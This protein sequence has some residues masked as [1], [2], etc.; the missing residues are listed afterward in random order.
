MRQCFSGARVRNKPASFAQNLPR[1][2]SLRNLESKRDI[3]TPGELEM[4]EPSAFYFVCRP[5]YR[6][7]LRYIVRRYSP[8]QVRFH[9]YVF[10]NLSACKQLQRSHEK[11]RLFACALL[12]LPV[13][14][15]DRP[16]FKSS[17]QMFAVV[18]PYS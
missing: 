5:R 13:A 12:G 4:C 16:Y 2:N 3:I 6:L 7:T 15:P 1:G 8:S 9:H 11:N 17:I 14:P 10:V 18:S